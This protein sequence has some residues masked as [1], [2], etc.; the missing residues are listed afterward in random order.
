[1]E[2]LTLAAAS[3][4]LYSVITAPGII[5]R[6]GICAGAGPPNTA[7][8]RWHHAPP[9]RIN[10]HSLPQVVLA[11]YCSLYVMASAP[12]VRPWKLEVKDTRP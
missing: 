3:R 4:L 1:M 7:V 2:V 9:E 8:Y 6:N 11:L 12:M 5:G 10:S